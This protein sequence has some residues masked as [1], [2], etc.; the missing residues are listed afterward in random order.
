MDPMRDPTALD[1]LRAV[2]DPV[3]L[4]SL[5]SAS[6]AD[7]SI[8]AL[9]EQLDVEPRVVAEAIGRLRAVGLLT[10]EGRVAETALRAIARMLPSREPGLG[11]SAS[12]PWTE[13][14]AE[15]LGR[16]FAGGRLTEIPAKAAKRRLVLEKI[17]QEFEPGLRYSERDVDFT[18]HLINED[19]AAIR[20]Y[21]VEEGFLA[22]ADG[23]YWR[24]GGRYEAPEE[25]SHQPPPLTLVPLTTE[26]HDIVLRPWDESMTDALVH[27]ADDSRIP[28]YM[29]N[30]F[31]NPYTREDAQQWV[32]MATSVQPS[33]QYAVFVDGRLAGGVGGFALTEEATG[34][35]EIGWWLNPAYW[36]RE[37][38]T[39]AVKALIYELFAHRDVQRVWAPVMAPNRASA[40]VAEKVGL[41]LEGVA[42]LHYVKAGV[43]HD[44]LNYGLTRQQ[45]AI[46]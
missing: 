16:F 20:R 42:P 33:M 3:R 5:G 2:L 23:V 41:V 14:E 34:V 18:I 15:M 24:S 4:A 38:A 35:A 6:R 21:L 26:R 13:A 29:G 44:Q 7:V 28:T 43:R 22:R 30:M 19:H 32:E 25:A 9:A 11:E 17:A 10:S 45:W 1:L 27:A 31:P 46:R 12:G 37:I 8:E 40:R 36:G 39:L